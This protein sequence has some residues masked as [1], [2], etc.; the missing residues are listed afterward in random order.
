MECPP[1]LDHYLELYKLGVN[2]TNHLMSYMTMKDW[3]VWEEPKHL[4]QAQEVKGEYEKKALK[5]IFGDLLGDS[6]GEHM[7]LKEAVEL[8][9]EGAGI[10]PEDQVQGGNGLLQQGPVP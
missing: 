10:C 5:K 3:F 9:K 6:W 8:A 4:L 2:L 1:T 7:T